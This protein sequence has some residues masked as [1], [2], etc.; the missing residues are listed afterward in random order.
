MGHG[1]DQADV[2]DALATHFLFGDFYPTTVTH[3]ALITDTLVLA[4][5]TF[6]VLYGT[7]DALAEQ[8]VA[9]GLV[10]AVVD[11]FGLQHF[12]ARALQKEFGRRQA[13]RDRVKAAGGLL[14]NFTHGIQ[15]EV[16]DERISL[17]ILSSQGLATHA[18]RH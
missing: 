5:G 2:A 16:A 13:D 7:E 12:T 14:F 3:D 11:R 6:K 15:N 1:H 18:A 10:S 17:R 8:S 9:F 4:T